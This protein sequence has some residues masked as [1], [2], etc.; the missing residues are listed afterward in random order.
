MA[1]VTRNDSYFRFHLLQNMYFIL[2]CNLKLGK[3]WKAGNSWRQKEKGSAE[4][5]MD[6]TDSMI[7][8][9]SKLWEMVEDRGATPGLTSKKLSCGL[10][11]ASP[12]RANQAHSLTKDA[13]LG[14]VRITG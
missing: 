11:A 10:T 6:I 5:D 1:Y 9:L 8:S 2:F 4:D 7:M 12:L 13:L 3:D 14:L